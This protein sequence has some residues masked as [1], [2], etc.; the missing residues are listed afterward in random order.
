MHSEPVMPQ[1]VPRDGGDALAIARRRFVRLYF[2][3]LILCFLPSKLVGATAAYVFLAGMVAY[4]SPVPLAHV[5][6]YGAFAIG[7]SALAFIY[8][9]AYRWFSVG[10]FYFFLVT[11]SAPLVLLCDF[12]GLVTPPVLRG[13]RRVT[14]WVLVLEALYG[15]AQG[16]VQIA[17]R[18]TTDVATGDA[19]RG[20]VEP[21][22]FSARGVGSNQIFALLVSSLVLFVIG[23]SERGRW[24]RTAPALG[25]ILVVY[26][27]ASVMHSILFFGV[28][29]C[30]AV[31]LS[32]AKGRVG[33][34]ALLLV[35]ALVGGLT[36]FFLPA[37]L[38]MAPR[39][40]RE[41]LDIRPWSPSP[42]A[43]ATYST[44][45]ELPRREPWQ[46]LVGLGP[47]QYSSRAA[48][49]RSGQYL[50]VDGIV[51]IYTTPYTDQFILPL[52]AP[53]FSGVRSG[54]TYF[55]FYS[56]LSLYGELGVPGVAAGVAALLWFVVKLSGA[57][58]RR[59]PL[60]SHS[61]TALALYV[62]LLGF[63]DNYWEWTQAVLPAFVL[64]RAGSQYL[65][66]GANAHP[67]RR[68]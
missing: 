12:R 65:D 64:L 32:R 66:R 48:L 7:Y 27:L 29:G 22:L 6:R 54:S 8:M 9:L 56:W 3:T 68:R 24:K 15:L 55:P 52:A 16:I 36:C 38:A 26:V 19:I 25:L 17:A 47:G 10:S 63:Q 33:R 1:P 4:V 53:F 58:D 35:V 13:M 51:P 5:G 49:I 34:G 46:P 37:N 57:G 60:L 39:M 28:A 30:V 62:A 18:G 40:V 43:F 31:G 50:S 67:P 23:T 59:F 21:Y 61:L 42:K 41:S 11:C 45:W 44:L 14:L 20:T 2:L